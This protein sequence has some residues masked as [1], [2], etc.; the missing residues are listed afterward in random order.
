MKKIEELGGK[1]WNDRYYFNNL[2]ELYGLELRFFKNGFN[3]SSALLEGEKLSNAKARELSGVL[4]GMKIW[5]EEGSGFQ[6]KGLGSRRFSAKQIAEKII[7]RLEKEAGLSRSAVMRTAWNIAREGAAKFGG[8]PSE[9]LSES[10]RLA[11]S[12]RGD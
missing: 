9:Y 11:W 8:K 12:K 1:R 7:G 2:Q 5:W 4:Q 10:L 6:W 3:I